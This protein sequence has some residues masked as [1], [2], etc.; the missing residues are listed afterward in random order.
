M[1]VNSAAYIEDLLIAGRS[2]AD[3]I[4]VA[5]DGFST[6]STEGICARYAD[7]VFRLEPLGDFSKVIV[8]L[9]EQCTGDWILR[10]DQDELP[11]TE[12][13]RTLPRLMDTRRFTHY[14]LRRR[15]VVGNDQAHWISQH[16]W[17]PD[18]Q[19]RLYRNIPSIIRYSGRIHT[20]FDVQGDFRHLYEGSIYH[21]D[22][23]YHSEAQRRRKVELYERLASGNIQGDFYLPHEPTLV[24]SPLP[25]DDMPLRI[26]PR[27][28]GRRG[29][30]GLLEKRGNLKRLT[31]RVQKISIT[32]IQRSPMQECEYGPGL[33]RGHLCTRGHLSVVSP[34]QWRSVDVELRNEST[35]TWASPDLGVPQVRVGYHWLHESG[36]MYEYDGHRTDLPHSLRPDETTR[37]A[38]S[39]R[40]PAEPGEY[41]LRWD[42]V[43]EN[44]SW[45]SVRG[46]R[47]PE[48]RVRVVDHQPDA[49]ITENGI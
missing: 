40:C 34:G 32:D 46:W 37:L 14:W 31:T 13:A 39:V 44:V 10:L 20:G 7:K 41:V 45:F 23:V 43:I 28:N 17:W 48:D 8:W 4:V 47:G 19:L 36:E 24:T 29:L 9:T 38:A 1:T 2:L 27:S 6:D 5:V 25:K 22:F 33:F 3:E 11:S 12:L 49:G 15:W 26:G 21:M 18:W 30:R 35:V 42:L 16:P